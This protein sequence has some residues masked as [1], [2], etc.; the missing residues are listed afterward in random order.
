MIHPPR[1]SLAKETDL[2]DILNLQ[3]LAYRSEAELVGDHRIPPLL[4]TLDDLKRQYETGTIICSM[5]NNAGL[6]IGSV[7]G[8]IRDKNLFIGKIMVHPRYQGQGYGKQ[9]LNYIEHKAPDTVVRFELFT[10]NLS[11]RNLSL[12]LSMGYSV[13]REQ[14]VAQKK[15]VFVF[16]EKIIPRAII[17]P[18]REEP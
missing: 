18:I 12:Y 5:H 13:F 7:R 15:W 11:K 10:S 16:M 17:F 14:A 4:E 2:P 8:T 1:L 3:Y 6:L 9:L